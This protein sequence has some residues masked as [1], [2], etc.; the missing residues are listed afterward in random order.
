[1]S[2]FTTTRYIQSHLSDD[3]KG[4]DCGHVDDFPSWGGGLGMG[5]VGALR[6]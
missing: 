3:Y 4:H 2:D 6:V 1:M 5:A